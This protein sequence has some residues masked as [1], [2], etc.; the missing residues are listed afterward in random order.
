MIKR[1]CENI[2]REELLLDTVSYCSIYFV[3]IIYLSKQFMF[4]HMYQAQSNHE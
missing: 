3:S 1:E 4:I 2:F